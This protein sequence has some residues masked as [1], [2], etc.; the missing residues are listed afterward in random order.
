VSQQGSAKAAPEAVSRYADITYGIIGAAMKVHN[1]LGPGLREVMYQRAL[2]AALRDA[3][4]GFEEEKPFEIHLDDERVGIIYLDHLVEGAVVV[5]EKAFP[6]LLTN[7]EVAQVLTYL[8]VA[9][10]PLGLLINFGRK[11]LEYRRILPPKKVTDS[12]ARLARYMWQPSEV[13]RE[14]SQVDH[15]L[16]RFSSAGVPSPASMDVSNAEQRP[17]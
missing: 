16:I 5:E 8:S 13:R 17:L 7:D 3:G 4:L 10:A 12:K 6:H 2:S 15:P 14:P 1:Q 9:E 11:R